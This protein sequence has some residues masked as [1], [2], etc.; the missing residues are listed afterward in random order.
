M[1]L[2]WLYASLPRDSITITQLSLLF[3]YYQV[4]HHTKTQFVTLYTF[5]SYFSVNL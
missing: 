2:L 4:N 1:P 5:Y 3:I